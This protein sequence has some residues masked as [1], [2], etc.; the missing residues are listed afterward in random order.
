MI[1][2]H[3]FPLWVDRV[4][5]FKSWE[6][7]RF[8]DRRRWEILIGIEKVTEPVLNNSLLKKKKKKCWHKQYL[9]KG[10]IFQNHSGKVYNFCMM[11][12]EKKIR[13]ICRSHV[14]GYNQNDQLIVLF[15]IKH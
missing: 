12:N 6:F 5:W 3:R 7:L 4:L 9:Q 13:S 14:I 11:P 2:Y 10:K 15:F 8:A 1:C